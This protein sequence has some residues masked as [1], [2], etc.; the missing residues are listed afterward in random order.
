[1]PYEKGTIITPILQIS[2]L[3]KVTELISGETSMRIP[4]VWLHNF[5]Y[6]F[7][8]TLYPFHYT[9]E[10][11]TSFRMRNWCQGSGILT[12]ICTYDIILS[13]SVTEW[14]QRS[15]QNRQGASSELAPVA[16]GSRTFTIKLKWALNSSPTM[17]ISQESCH[18]NGAQALWVYWI[19]ICLIFKNVKKKLE[20]Y[21]LKYPKQTFKIHFLC[22]L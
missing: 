15:D 17:Q 16:L 1:M 9:T 7:S 3:S 22:S 13:L 10:Q 14:K 12:E 11:L 4:A 6:L 19:L 5:L 21:T 2:N 8:L 18:N 20:V